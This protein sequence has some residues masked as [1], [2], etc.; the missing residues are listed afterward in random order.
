MD[1]MI[2]DIMCVGLIV[3]NNYLAGSFTCITQKKG[4][5]LLP[6]RTAPAERAVGLLFPVQLESPH[7]TTPHTTHQIPVGGT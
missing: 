5:C 3:S 1:R 7:H 6:G 4:C 2:P